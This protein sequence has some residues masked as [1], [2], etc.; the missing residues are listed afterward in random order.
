MTQGTIRESHYVMIIVGCLF[1][2][3]VVIMMI[4]TRVTTMVYE[5]S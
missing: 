4:L 2:T 3:F 5:P 1:K